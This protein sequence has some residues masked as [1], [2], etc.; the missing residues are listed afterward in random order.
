MAGEIALRM[1]NKL[2]IFGHVDIKILYFWLK[3]ETSVQCIQNKSL[4]TY[5]EI[6][7][8]Y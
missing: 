3:K 6:V 7:V 5:F 4:K 1:Y 2:S 8:I